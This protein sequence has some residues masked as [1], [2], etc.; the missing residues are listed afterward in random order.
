MKPP[1]DAAAML[2]TEYMKTND[3]I[4]GTGIR[5]KFNQSRHRSWILLSR[6]AVLRCR[7]LASETAL[8]IMETVLPHYDVRGACV[9]R[10]QSH[11]S[12]TGPTRNA[13]H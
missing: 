12:D 2:S 11:Y 13:R 4:Y 10:T 1:R 8:W 5:S 6:L 3:A 9:H 7:T